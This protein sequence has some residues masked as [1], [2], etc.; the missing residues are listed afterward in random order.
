MK[1]GYGNRIKY[2]DLQIKAVPLKFL[3]TSFFAAP[4]LVFTSEAFLFMPL[5]L[6][7]NA[8]KLGLFWFAVSVIS[9]SNFCFLQ[10]GYSGCDKPLLRA[11]LFSDSSLPKNWTASRFDI[12]GHYTAAALPN[13]PS[14]FHC[15][16]R[17]IKY[18]LK[19][20]RP[21]PKTSCFSWSQ[22][23]SPSRKQHLAGPI[24]IV[25]Q[26]HQ[27][28]EERSKP[29]EKLREAWILIHKTAS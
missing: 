10:P 7:L 19:S 24:V 28:D 4:G 11:G 15:V 20:S 1:S 2:N 13:N 17:N 14:H 9:L 5:G 3:M 21:Q 12:E 22:S 23:L 16:D 25:W 6:A 8:E 26:V 18:L 27:S 29:Q